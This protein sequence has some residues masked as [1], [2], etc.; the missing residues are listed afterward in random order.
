MFVNGNNVVS[1][2]MLVVVTLQ[3]LVKHFLRTR[4]DRRFAV[5]IVMI[6]R[7]M[8]QISTSVLDI[9]I[10]VVRQWP[11]WWTLSLSLLW[12]KTVIIFTSDSFGCE[13]RLRA[14]DDDLLL[15]PVLSVILKI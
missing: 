3:S 9:A 6:C 11:I 10:F 14:P 1:L 4:P 8:S 7:T 15:L 2:Y 13:L 12:L 5:G